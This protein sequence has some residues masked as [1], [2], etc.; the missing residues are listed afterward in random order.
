MTDE[1]D[2]WISDYLASDRF[3]PFIL[4]VILLTMLSFGWDVE[5]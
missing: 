5:P 4:N 3:D 1:I 2:P